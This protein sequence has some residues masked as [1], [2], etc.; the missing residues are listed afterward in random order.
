M[1][2]QLRLTAEGT[3]ADPVILTVD[4]SHDQ[5]ER[6]HALGPAE[7]MEFAVRAPGALAE[8]VEQPREPRARLDVHEGCV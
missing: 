5:L 2:G 1:D 4:V 3:G 6:L 8:L 7:R